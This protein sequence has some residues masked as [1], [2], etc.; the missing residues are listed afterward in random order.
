MNPNLKELQ[1]MSLE[2]K[3]AHSLN[4]ISRALRHFDN[5]MYISVSGGKDSMVLL[6]LVRRV[7]PNIKAVFCNTGQ[8]W[9]EIVYFTRTID[10]LETIRPKM[11]FKKVIEH[12][13][14]PVISKEQSQFI[15]E[16]RTTK[17]EKLKDIRLNGNKAGMGKL[18]K[19]W[20]YMLD[21]PF[22]ISHKCCDKLKKEPFKRYEKATGLSPFI[23]TMAGE[24]RLRA[25]QWKKYSCNAFEKNRP[26]SNPLTI[27]TEKDI[28]EYIKMFN[29]PYCEIYNVDGIERTGCLFCMYGIHKDK[30]SKFD[31]VKQRHPKLYDNTINKLG[32]GNVINYLMEG[33]KN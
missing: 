12:Y 7:N 32:C 18:S 26:S 15:H 6:D 27:W 21:A 23:G 9:P 4:V 3:V 25:Q 22:K 20:Y 8:E 33:L 17:S 24:S 2:D 14:Y 29:V 1:D 19:K 28:W 30:I 31:I 5:Q 16:I 11:N 10:N 13:G